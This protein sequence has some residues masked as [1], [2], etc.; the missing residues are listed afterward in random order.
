MLLKLRKAEFQIGKKKKAY[1]RY[2]IFRDLIFREISSGLCYLYLLR[3][4]A[5]ICQGRWLWWV[6][7][8]WLLDRSE[9]DCKHQC[10]LSHSEPTLSIFPS[11]PGS[12]NN[13][14]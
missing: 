14:E 11:S 7:S 10:F 9:R 4:V 2:G 8:R 6:Q 3:H 13:R 5:D 12:V 1:F